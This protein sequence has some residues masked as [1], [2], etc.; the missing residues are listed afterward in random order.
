MG[1]LLKGVAKF[2]VAAA[3]VGGLCYMFKDQI[4]ESKVYKEHDVDGKINKVKSTIK[5]KMPKIFENEEDFVEDDEIFFND[6]GMSAEDT[7]R[8]Y[9]DIDAESTPATEDV[10]EAAEEAAE[11]T[12]EVPT[13]DL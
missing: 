8:D 6:E 4:K 2:T 12:A 7:A 10:S 13:I 9:V 5:E 11:E 1:K 3:A